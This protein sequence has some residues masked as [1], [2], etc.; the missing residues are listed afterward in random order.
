MTAARGGKEPVRFMP[1]NPT[2]S[3][4][5]LLSLASWAKPR[6]RDQ[7]EAA[8]TD[9]DRSARA[10]DALHAALSGGGA[11]PR[12]AGPGRVRDLLLGRANGASHPEGEASATADRTVAPV[13]VAPPAVIRA[14]MAMGKTPRRGLMS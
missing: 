14:Q 3:H 11:R 12:A 5:A 9:D 2:R 1:Q 8:A 4:G 6:E 10:G 13:P 7:L